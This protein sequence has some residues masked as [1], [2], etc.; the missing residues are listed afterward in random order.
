MICMKV[1]HDD[2]IKMLYCC[3]F[4]A[5][6]GTIWIRSA[7]NH[8][9]RVGSSADQEHISLADITADNIPISIHCRWS[10]RPERHEVGNKC[11][12]HQ[13]QLNNVGHGEPLYCSGEDAK[14]SCL[15]RIN[16]DCWF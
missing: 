4:Q 5:L 2:E 10:Y 14:P 13:T 9:G 12:D 16:F 3:C 15:G 11:H 1:C 7:I 8:H 6:S